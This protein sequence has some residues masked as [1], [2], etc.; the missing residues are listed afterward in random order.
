MSVYFL[1][2]SRIAVGSNALDRGSAKRVA[3]KDI[4]A[5]RNRRDKLMSAAS[6]QLIVCFTRRAGYMKSIILMIN[7]KFLNRLKNADVARSAV[8]AIVGVNA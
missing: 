6:G 1:L 7:Y 3:I 8:Q 5:K 2:M 4:G